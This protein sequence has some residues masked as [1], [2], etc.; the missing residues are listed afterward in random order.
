MTHKCRG[1]QQ[2]LRVVL[3]NLLI[4]D[5]GAKEY[6]Q[7]LTTELT[8]QLDLE[9]ILAHRSL[10]VATVCSSNSKATTT[11]S[12]VAIVTVTVT[13]GFEC[14]R[15]RDGWTGVAWTSLNM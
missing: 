8:V 7:A 11:T 15:H 14:G 5:K 1:S 2:S 4:R 6:L 13:V 12:T 9:I 3:P 10:S